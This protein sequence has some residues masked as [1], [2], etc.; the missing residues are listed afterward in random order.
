MALDILV[1]RKK[2]L[3][4]VWLSGQPYTLTDLPDR[5]TQLKGRS[6]CTISTIGLPVLQGGETAVVDIQLNGVWQRFF[7]GV[8]D[9]RSAK[10][11]PISRVVHLID[12]LRKLDSAA[13]A[14]ITWSSTSFPDAVEDLL[15]AAGI[16]NIGDIFD[17]GLTLGSEED[18]VIS[19][20]ENLNSVMDEL[21][22]YGGAAIFVDA[23]GTVQ[24][25]DDSGIPTESGAADYKESAD[26]SSGEYPF[27]S[28]EEVL[29]GIEQVVSIFTAKGPTRADG[30]TPT[31]T[32]TIEGVNGIAQGMEYRFIQTAAAAET[33]AEREAARR[34]RVKRTLSLEGPSNP[35]LRP[36]QT[37]RVYSPLVGYDELTPGLIR[38]ASVN[39]V[40]MRLTLEIGPSLVDGFT[41]QQAPVAD[42]TMLVEA[43]PIIVGGVPVI[44]YLV[45]C[46]DQSYDPDGEIVNR[47]FTPSAGGSPVNSTSETPIFIFSSLSGATITLEVEDAEGFIST[48]TKDVP[49]GVEDILTRQISVA[50]GS[51]GWKILLDGTA[52]FVT[53]ARGGTECRSVPPFNENGRLIAGWED[54]TIT[55]LDENNEMQIL[56]QGT[57]NSVNA[58]YVNEGDPLHILAARDTTLSR[59]MDGGETFVD[60][61]EFDDDILDVQS[62]PSNP[63]EVR[64]VS[65][66]KLYL[67]FGGD[68]DDIITGEDDSIAEMI[69]TA[70]WG[71][72]VVFSNTTN[73]DFL[74]ESEERDSVDWSAVPIP[75]TSLTAITPYLE[76]EGFF[77]GD[78]EGNIYSMDKSGITYTVNDIGQTDPVNGVV[79]DMIRDGA[80]P[81]L[82]FIADNDGLYKLLNGAT[83]FQ[84]DLDAALQV[85][86]GP[87]SAAQETP[88]L[89]ILLAGLG[90]V[91]YYDS[92]AETWDDLGSG[93]LPAVQFTNVIRNPFDRDDW[94]VYRSVT[95]DDS[96]AF[97]GG[98]F[99]LILTG[100]GTNS[101][102]WRTTDGGTT[103]T[104][105]TLNSVSGSFPNSAGGLY[106]EFD[107]ILSGR[108]HVL[109]DLG[110]NGSNVHFVQLW[111]G[112][113][114]TLAGTNVRNGEANGQVRAMSVGLSGETL[115]AYASSSTT[116][117]LYYIGSA[118]VFAGPTPEGYNAETMD[119]LG[120]LSR[121]VAL[122]STA[123]D[124]FIT[125]TDYRTNQSTIKSTSQPFAY[126][127]ASDNAVYVSA[128]TPY[129]GKV[130]N[131]HSATPTITQ[132][133]TTFPGSETPG[134][135]RVDRDDR[136]A[137]AVKVINSKDVVVSEDG[138]TFVRITGPAAAALAEL[139]NCVEVIT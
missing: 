15:T 6:V 32:F 46:R 57:G 97:S 17:P 90:V 106:V 14:E 25:V 99:K 7:T 67:T 63:D 5:D 86:Y 23:N 29:S 8:V 28:V 3:A 55:Y 43:E 111:R 72:A 109:L 125:T 36:G 123:I 10:A 135:I 81:G 19:P 66:N 80:L 138:I 49:S 113:G 42:F 93:Q 94:I 65:G 22:K 91:W 128:D 124:A 70:P 61:G 47:E 119:R 98:S 88:K 1:T 41:N 100:G 18:I 56:W 77:V 85:G 4:R 115:L 20:D 122:V 35:N 13:D 68:F 105:I 95:G 84:A 134:H 96:Y 83:L 102:V 16:T 79:N 21:L 139:A 33:I 129:I 71:H 60:I 11:A 31:F 40:D 117:G 136:T 82:V 69:A 126:I 107:P 133:Y 132:L 53:Y 48:T 87:L 52:G 110:S 34:A 54:D 103:W 2:W 130:T 9:Q 27:Y 127:S 37:I 75:P 45:Q 73:E 137:V 118:L 38:Q 131:I 120:G 62:S 64:V 50:C 114:A 116:S 24:V 30:V 58:L 108:I 59:S 121:Q 78:D 104:Q 74:F 44:R 12:E 39:G 89:D 26:R 112:T 76:T 101:P 92:D 51:V